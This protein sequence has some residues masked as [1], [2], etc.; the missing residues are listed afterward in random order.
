MIYSY[1][2]RSKPLCYNTFH[3]LQLT[4]CL[5]E[6]TEIQSLNPQLRELFNSLIITSIGSIHEDIRGLAVRALNLICILNFDIAQNYLIILL[7]VKK[8]FCF[9]EY[10]YYFFSMKII[11][12]DKNEVV[13]EAFKA[14]INSI[15]AYSLVKLVGGKDEPEEV[16][17]ENTTQIMSI[18]TSLLDHRVSNWVFN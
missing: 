1:V 10:N 15:M 4:V 13:F 14:I 3:C 18:L 11:Q 2:A 6:D 9:V 12:S 17:T 5:L 8:C 7:G 16:R